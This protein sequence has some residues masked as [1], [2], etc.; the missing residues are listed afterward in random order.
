MTKSL[1]LSLL[2]GAAV[3]GHAA[4]A[5]TEEFAQ[6]KYEYLSACA[7]CHGENADG[8]G[9]IGT[10]FA[11]AIPDLTGIAKRND[12]VFPVLKIFQ[13]V[14]GRTAMKAHGNPMPIFG[15]RFQSEVGDKAGAFGGELQVRARV[16][17]LVFYL[18][19]IQK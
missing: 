17:E 12:G 10:M 14:D 16:L 3:W 7:G 15:R 11:K 5:E 8:K 4:V 9:P 1:A 19:S 2:L 6:G 18:Q 13:L